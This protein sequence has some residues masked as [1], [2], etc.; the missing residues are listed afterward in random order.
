[1]VRAS[2]IESPPAVASQRAFDRLAPGVMGYHPTRSAY[3]GGRTADFS[4][5]F[6]QMLQ[7]RVQNFFDAAQFRSPQIAHVIETLV[8]R[9]KV[10][11]N[12]CKTLFVLQ[13]DKQHSDG[14]GKVA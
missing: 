5:S 10:L 4:M 2:Q 9:C 12:R 14:C 11:I 3:A 8:D 1:M 13:P 6:L 7:A